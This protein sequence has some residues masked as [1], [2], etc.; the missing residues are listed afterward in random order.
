MTVPVD[1][2]RVVHRLG[3]GLPISAGRRQ[4]ARHDRDL[5]LVGRY[6]RP[7]PP[8]GRP[9]A[10]PPAPAELIVR[11]PADLLAAVP[12]LLG[13]HP[14]TSV[15]IV[16]V[17]ERQMIFAAR[18]D[19]PPPGAAAAEVAAMTGYVGAVVAQQEGHAAAVVG[20]GPAGRVDP[21]MPA[22]MAALSDRGLAIM[23]V[24]RVDDGRFWSYLC[25]D[26]RCCPPEG[27]PF[28][29]RASPLAAAAAYAGQVALPS[30][31][32]LV[33]Q[34]SPVGGAD[35]I[36][37]RQATRR[38]ETRLAALLNGAPP[39][40]LLGGRALRVAGERAVRD[41]LGQGRSGQRPTDDE[42]AWSTLLLAHTPVRDYACQRLDD[43]EW[44]LTLWGDVV[45]R[46]RSD[47]VAAPATLLALAAWRVGHGALANV[48][49][50]RALSA[51][52]RYWLALVLR[53]ALDSGIG[54]V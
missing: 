44:Q 42:L 25:A 36:A 14:D 50:D 27:T 48:A 51:D 37:M 31:V 35:Q 6:S 28:D 8:S 23:A 3:G 2:E 53:E 19:L 4:A 5:R 13:F 11:S 38:A 49:L 29:P 18:A 30:R 10:K 21:V 17:R 16:A 45:R 34:V 9:S 54:P 7:G 26:P 20:Y 12:Y 24:L 1:D 43:G 46:A 15:V 47:L 39:T 41:L 32:D 52:P 22:A 40:D 33:R